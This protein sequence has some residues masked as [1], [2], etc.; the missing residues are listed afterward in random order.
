M[1]FTLS[2][3]AFQHNE[4]MPAKFTCHGIDVSPPLTWS[5]PPAGTESFALI[6][7]DPEAVTGIY[8]QWVV[9]NLPSN[10]RELSEAVTSVDDLPGNAT[11]GV[12]S[13]GEAGYTGPCPDT[14]TDR[15]VFHL[16]ALDTMLN[17]SLGVERKDVEAQMDG[18]VL[19]EAELIGIYTEE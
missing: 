12:N 5:D 14:T 3:E 2:S 19:D 1:A 15:A 17:A 16:Y 10:T 9:C 13:M 6:V 8:T 11:L 4:T 7:E 18:H